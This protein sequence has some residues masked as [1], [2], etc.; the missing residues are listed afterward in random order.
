MNLHRSLRPSQRSSG[1][2]TELPPS[3]I[4]VTGA[5]ARNPKAKHRIEPMQLDVQ[6][7]FAE[8]PAAR[9]S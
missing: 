8:K 5:S 1:R 4:L 3:V 7:V 9:S 2:S 6:N